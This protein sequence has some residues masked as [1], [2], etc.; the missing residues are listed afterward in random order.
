MCLD[1]PALSAGAHIYIC[2]LFCH[3]VSSSVTFW[4]RVPALYVTVVLQIYMIIA[5][6]SLFYFVT[7]LVL[8]VLLGCD[9][10]LH[11]L[12]SLTL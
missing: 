8:F 1:L 12:T 3:T 7:F 4:F 11:S 6:L 9:I 10:G 5:I 2:A